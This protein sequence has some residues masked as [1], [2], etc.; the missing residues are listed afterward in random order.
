MIPL[1]AFRQAATTILGEGAAPGPS[2][3]LGDGLLDGI[4][5]DTTALAG[6]NAALLADR[7]E[8][9]AWLARIAEWIAGDATRLDAPVRHG[10][11]AL[12]P[13]LSVGRAGHFDPATLDGG[14]PVGT[15]WIAALEPMRFFQQAADHLEVHGGERGMRLAARLRAPSGNLA[16]VGRLV[17]TVAV[18]LETSR[19]QAT[20]RLRVVS[21]DNGSARQ[22]LLL[23]QGWRMRR[24][25]ADAADA[26]VFAHARM[27]RAGNRVEMAVTG[28][29]HVVVGLFGR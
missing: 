19:A 4:P 20:L 17:D 9:R 27:G 14:V 18:S 13:L 5:A 3:A 25:L 23:L 28:D 15:A 16:L 24:S 10:P 22:T 7:P 6:A 12:W 11:L 2:V 21:P 26:P 1:Q 29:A 8:V